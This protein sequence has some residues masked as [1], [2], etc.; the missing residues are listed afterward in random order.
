MSRQ[1]PR[2]R[3]PI[4]LLAAL[5][6][7]SI[8]FGPPLIS[9]RADDCLAKPNS[10]APAGSRWYYHFD[11]ATQ[12]KCW[13]MGATH[14]PLEAVAAEATSD[15]A[16]VSAAPSIPS[17]MPATASGPLSIN[18]SNSSTPS[19]PIKAPV[20]PKRA[21]V[22]D[23]ATGQSAGAQ[24]ATPQ[25]LSIQAPVPQARP[26]SQTSDHGATGFVPTPAWPDPPVVPFKLQEQTAPPSDT[27]IESSQPAADTPNSDT[28]S[29][30]DAKST[31]AAETTTS[32]LKN[33][34]AMFAI[35]ALGLVVAGILL[36]AVIKIS[37][38]KIFPG[39]RLPITTDEHDFDRM[40]DLTLQ[41][42][43]DQVVDDALSGYLKRSEI[44][45]ESDSKRRQPS[46]IG[47]DGADITRA[48][49]S[50]FHMTD[51]INMRKHRRIDVKP[52]QS[53]SSDA[54]PQRE[55]V[56]IDPKP[57]SIDDRQYRARNGQRQHGS[58]GETD[59]FLHDLQS[60]LTTAASEYRAPP[61][62]LQTADGGP[63][64]GR[65]KDGPS[66]IGDE[67]R[68]REEALE[69]LRRDLDQLLQ[70]PK[71]A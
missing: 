48:G 10:P 60:S 53:A 23:A 54:K 1:S 15:S 36:R 70:S 71:V 31:V 25:A 69:R 32:A 35:V 21:S 64:D 5:L 59:D 4:A 26:S 42:H 58:V 46:Q 51:T 8:E 29:V 9:A 45:V 30:T 47:T 2:Q 20:K 57:A 61:S 18:A 16:S 19:P 33:P 12:R 68:E 3:G 43:E 66:Q 6:V 13:H 63:I 28:K 49:D 50:V 27:R 22:S 44:S 55:S 11:K 39:R 17:E 24:K 67:I 7:W 40:D 62:P 37:V 52:R 41:L 34:L 65:G 14:Q 56:S 38:M